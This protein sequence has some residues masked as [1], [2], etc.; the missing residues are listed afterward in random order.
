MSVNFDCVCFDLDGTIC[1]SKIG[2]LNGLKHTFKQL[3]ETDKSEDYYLQFIGLSLDKSLAKFTDFNN[4][5]IEK[6]I[7]IFREFYGNKGIYDGELY[8]GIQEVIKKLYNEGVLLFL[9]TAKPQHFAEKIL[10]HFKL[11]DFF[12]D[13]YGLDPSLPYPGKSVHLKDIKNKYTPE[14][15]VMIGDRH[16][17]IDAANELKIISI[18]VTYG[19]GSKE[20]LEKA[21]PSYFAHNCL[22]ILNLIEK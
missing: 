12:K 11:L 19:Y 22:E 4:E 20:E 17:D 6:A 2:I 8:P 5:K 21:S 9:V 3:G 1:D 14:K 10:K 15:I 18:A 13:V 16:L 7:L